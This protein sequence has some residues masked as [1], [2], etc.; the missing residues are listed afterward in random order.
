ML[1]PNFEEADGLGISIQGVKSLGGDRVV[2][3]RLGT[4]DTDKWQINLC[5]CATV[6]L[7]LSGLPVNRLIGLS[8]SFSLI[9]LGF[10][11]LIFWLMYLP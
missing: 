1:E 6:S 4:G 10:G 5:L 9:G 7:V 8:R 3:P 2:F 11:H